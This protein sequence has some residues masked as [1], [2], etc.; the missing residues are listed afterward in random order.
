MDSGYDEKEQEAGF[1]MIDKHF[2]ELPMLEFWLN[3]NLKF[4]VF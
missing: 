2:L 1:T 4:C 3:L